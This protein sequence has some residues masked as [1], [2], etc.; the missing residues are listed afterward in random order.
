MPTPTRQ[1]D[2]SAA[3]LITTIQELSKA[4]DLKTIQ[5][6]VRSAARELTGADGATFVLRDGDFCFYADED[7][8]EPLWKGQ[9][10]PLSICISGWAMLNRAATVIPDIYLDDRIPHDAYRPTFVQSLVMVPIRDTDPIGA[11]G[12]YWAHHHQATEEEVALLQALANSTAI[13]MENVGVLTRLEDLVAART[14]ELV[15]ANEE[16]AAISTIDELTGLLNRRGFHLVAQQQLESLR[17][18]GRT[19]ELLFIDIDG[20]KA[21]N[22]Q[23]GHEA[24]DALIQLVAHGLTLASRDADVVARLGGDEFVILA[25][26]RASGLADRLRSTVA[27]AGTD[28]LGA[29]PSISIGSVTV[30][31]D[32]IHSLAGLIAEADRAMYRDKQ[33]RQLTEVS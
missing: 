5:A 12:N 7:A 6:I 9:R 21:V 8:I 18:E 15:A 2:E 16:L 14:A 11:I 25:S 28:G 32:K 19:G 17:R 27:V 33:G 29:S 3:R 26:S 23:A 4:R 31:P 22:D 30:D 20:L 24:G 1:L 10:F 13:A